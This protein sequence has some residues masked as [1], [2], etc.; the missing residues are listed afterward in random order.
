MRPA[1]KIIIYDDTCPMCSAYT[2]AFVQTGLIDSSGRKCFSA[3]SPKILGEI[4]TCRNEIPL[5]DTAV[6]T[7][8]YGIDALLEIL[9]AR[10]P[11][12][13]TIGNAKP[14][15]WFLKRL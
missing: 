13:K 3:I 11:L 2:K 4:D 1:N 10:W 9:G 15:N 5:I 12:I 8:K 14:V 7:V 6:H